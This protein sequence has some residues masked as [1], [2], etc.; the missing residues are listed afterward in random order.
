[1]DRGPIFVGG[2]DRSG[3]TQMRLSLSSHPNISMTRRTYMWTH[4]YNRYGDLAKAENFERCLA[5]MLRRKHMA[6]LQPDPERIRREFGQGQP[7]YGRLFALFHEH[8]AER[9]SKPRWGDQLGFIERY[10]DPIFAAYPTARIIQMVR[11]PRDRF[12]AATS[13]EQR[14]GGKIG[15]A[16]ARWLASVSL[17]RG[18][19]RRYPDRYMVVR[20]EALAAR[21]EQTLREVCAFIGEAFVPA[22]LTLEGAMRFGD[23][24]N[25]PGD[26]AAVARTSPAMS[27]REVAFVQA[28]AGRAMAAYGYQPQPVRLSLGERL[29][30]YLVDWPTN[31]ARIV[32]WR[33]LDSAKE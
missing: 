15:M 33:T 24:D 28:C 17:A 1:M 5:A 8:Y 9:V 18:N 19:Q 22:M 14:R 20:Y 2:L 31:L 27:R 3:K 7:T 10:A 30:L 13:P 25:E 26:R 21:P 16:T 32:A 6:V 11:D 23:E 12:A 4:V 29:L